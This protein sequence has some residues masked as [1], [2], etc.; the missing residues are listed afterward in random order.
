MAQ[1]MCQVC[2]L[3]V[4]SASCALGDA[5]PMWDRLPKLQEKSHPKEPQHPGDLA[6]AGQFRDYLR[7]IEPLSDQDVTKTKSSSFLTDLFK[8][9]IPTHQI[10]QQQTSSI[11]SGKIAFFVKV[12]F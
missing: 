7:I 11:H 9:H 5:D 2:C 12:G 1:L 3:V 4:I 6:Q 10:K 8:S